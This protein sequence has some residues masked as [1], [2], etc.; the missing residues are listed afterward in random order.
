MSSAGSQS[1]R[2]SRFAWAGGIAIIALI[3]GFGVW[4][5]QTTLAGAV[6]ASGQ[7][8]VEAHRQVVE[9]PDGGVVSSILVKDGDTVK[10]GQTLLIIEGRIARSDLTI[11]QGQL[12]ELHARIARLRA[13]R[14]G[15]S[16][17]DFPE[18]YGIRAASDGAFAELLRG[19]RRLFEARKATLE[20]SVRSLR[21]QQ[22]QIRNQI[23]GQEAQI[24]SANTQLRLV[25]EELAGAQKL[26]ERGLIEISRVKALQREQARLSGGKGELEAAV[27]GNRGRIAQIEVEIVKQRAERSEAA[28]SELRDVSV[29]TAELAEKRNALLGT[30]SRLELKAP[31]D[32]VVH[33]MQI[34][35][36]GA[37]IRPAEPVLYIVPRTRDLVVSAKVDIYHVDSVHPGQDAVLRFS[38]F[39]ARSTPE[40]EGAVLRVSPDAVNDERTG[41]AYYT[42]KIAAKP[43]ELPRLGEKSL[44]PGMPVDVFIQTGERSPLSFLL[45]PFSDYFFRAFRE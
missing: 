35:A 25:A 27:A 21:E 13:E 24:A 36:L 10:A 6:V 34:H 5:T 14:S 17:L 7:V 3:A 33:E 44:I 20:S 29:R 45:K 4:G 19:Q 42:V 32:G 38:A 2:T 15:L 8:Q 28:V 11:V 30:L 9:H 12:D 22:A 18:D 43:D 39:D 31:M 37:V 23:H 40:L 1:W 26:F 16:E 41:A